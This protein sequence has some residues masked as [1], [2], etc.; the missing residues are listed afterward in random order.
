MK[1]LFKSKFVKDLA[2]YNLT[3]LWLFAH[4]L[5][6]FCSQ[7][8]LWLKQWDS[9]VFGSE[10]RTTSDDVFSSLRRHSSVAQHQKFSNRSFSG[11]NREFKLSKETFKVQNGLDLENNDS[12]GIP[13][14]WNKKANG[15]GPPEQKVSYENWFK[16]SFHCTKITACLCFE[17]YFYTIKN[18]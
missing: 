11:K 16:I 9:C 4:H 5:R 7:V 17:I 10:I 13:E 1:L 18:Q 12:K 6:C 8:L 14:L 3:L 2:F 15:S